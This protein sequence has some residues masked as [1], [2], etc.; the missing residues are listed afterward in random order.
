MSDRGWEPICHFV[1]Y[2]EQGSQTGPFVRK[3]YNV[4]V[5]IHRRRTIFCFIVTLTLS[6][7]VL[8]CVCV[9][10]CVWV[11]VRV[12]ARARARVCVCVWVRACVH[13]CAG[14]C[15]HARVRAHEYVCLCARAFACFAA[16]GSVLLVM[17][18]DVLSLAVPFDLI[19]YNLFPLT[20]HTVWPVWS[21]TLY[22]LTHCMSWHT[23]WPDTL[24]IAYSLWPDIITVIPDTLSPLP[25][26]WNSVTSSSLLNVTLSSLP[27]VIIRCMPLALTCY[28]GTSSLYHD[29]LPFLLH[30][31]MIRTP[32]PLS[33]HIIHCNLFC[34]TWHTAE[35]LSFIMT[36]CNLF[37]HTWHTVTSSFWP[38]TM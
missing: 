25:L 12:C 20:W 31:I 36:Q 38:D 18:L 22:D 9:S 28:T 5:S 17:I 10:V 16:H 35:P 30:Y 3:A 19:H 4:Y 37:P 29:T 33:S 13:A 7:S 23:V 34:L 14:V 27:S 32:S 8:V 15:M 21:D 26:L 6:A 24:Y 2:G 1:Q 11:C